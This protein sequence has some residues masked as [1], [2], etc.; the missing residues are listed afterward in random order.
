MIQSAD[1][2]FPALDRREPHI[3]SGGEVKF[4][5]SGVESTDP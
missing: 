2:R 3:R 1:I 4:Q 5:F